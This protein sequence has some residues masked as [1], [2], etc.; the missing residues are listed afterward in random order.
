MDILNKS[1]IKISDL[2]RN[3]NNLNL[4]SFNDNQNTSGDLVKKLDIISH[5]IIASELSDNQEIAGYIS[6]ESAEITFLSKTGKYIVAFDPLDG[7]SNISCNVSIGTI[8]GIYAWDSKNN[9]I[10][11]IIDAG[12]CL[13]GP[14]TI[15][16]RT[17][18]DIVKIYQLINNKYFDFISVLSLKNKNEKNYSINESNI[19]FMS[20]NIQ[21]I[22]KNYKENNYNTRWIGSMVADAHRTLIQGG[23]FMYPGNTKNP[24]G[25]LRLVY[26]S[27]PIAKIFDV[28]GGDSWDGEKNILENEID[29]KNIHQKIP[30]FLGT[31]KNINIIKNLNKIII[32]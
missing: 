3:S 29:L 20:E 16:V 30:T 7:S 9:K 28:C 21:D 18:N 24:L 14:S 27:L 31:K 22:I 12:Y 23:I 4:S 15:L 13:Y 19:P 8:Y 26:E 25:K 2:I 10:G 11:K 1:F 17:E 32:N 5:N 6:E